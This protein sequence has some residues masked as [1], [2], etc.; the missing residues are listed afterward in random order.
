MKLTDVQCRNA[1]PRERPY[2]LTDGHGLFL[3]VKP[4]GSKLWRQDHAFQ[5]KRRTANFGP[6]PATTLAQ[7][8]DMRDELKQA[9][10]EGRDPSAKPEDARPTFE[11][12]AREW[13]S[14]NVS[15]WKT[16]Y[17]ARFWRQIERDVFTVVGSK[18]IAD[19]EPLQIL[20]S[21]RAIEGRDA[22][23]TARR[24][25][26]MVNQICKFAV[27]S[28]HIKHN[29]AAD[30]HVALK[31]VPREKH[32]A[33]LKETDLPKFLMK[34]GNYNGER[35]TMLAL[36]VVA[37]TFVR[38]NEIRF[39]K[40]R[41]FEGDMWRISAERMKMGREHLVPL[42]RQASAL[43]GQLR[44]IAGESEWV[45]P[46]PRSGKPISENTLLYAL[47]RLGYHSR[48]SVHG[49]RATASTILNESGLWR[50]D[51]IERQLAHVPEDQI[52]AAYNRG[53]FWDERVRM[54][55]WYSDLLDKHEKAGIARDFSDLLN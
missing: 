35:Q 15:K 31:P 33:A 19:I 9:I 54:M 39:A 8:R 47:Y 10:S 43:F 29:P 38:T 1:K 34:L 20:E 4:N 27:V 17:S 6:Y 41:E 22:V 23:Y 16:S 21:L 25:H 45:L 52:R 28:G 42:S 53:T 13:F 37:H 26:Q 2:N 30:L 40:W 24:I 48:A 18:A 7:A 11:K 36:R 14:A 3:L 44:M 49:F 32:R 55:Q 50:P 12:I 51:V 46:G 5:G